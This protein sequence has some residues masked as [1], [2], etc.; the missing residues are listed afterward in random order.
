MVKR[1]LIEAINS[2][3]SNSYFRIS[4]GYKIEEEDKQVIINQENVL[5][6]LEEK[7]PHGI[8]IYR[9]DKL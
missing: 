4:L 1:E 6:V 8:Y 9:F 3:K 2:G 7:R 5:P